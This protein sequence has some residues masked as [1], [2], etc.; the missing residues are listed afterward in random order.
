[1][2]CSKCGI[3]NPDDASFCVKC[4][5]K[6]DDDYKEGIAQ[7][8]E[9]RLVKV[10][11]ISNGQCSNCKEKV[12][13]EAFCPKCKSPLEFPLKKKSMITACLLSLIL[14]GLGNMYAGYWMEG[15]LF[16]FGAVVIGLY[17]T[18]NSTFLY[19][20]ILRLI[21]SGRAGVNVEHVNTPEKHIKMK[22]DG[23]EKVI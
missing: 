8:T 2:Y 9:E 23:N 11:Y 13:N 16:F 5:A 20:I 17:D 18:I 15:I 4:G 14:P 12:T 21:A 1:M 22:F 6:I 10:A 7:K 19:S 3:Q